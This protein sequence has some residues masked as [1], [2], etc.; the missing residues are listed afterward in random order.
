MTL[1]I[2]T[3]IHFL[4]EF[5]YLNYSMLPSRIF[6]VALVPCRVQKNVLSAAPWRTR[7]FPVMFSE[8]R[9]VFEVSCNISIAAKRAHVIKTKTSGHERFGRAN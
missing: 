5:V 4:F 1:L 2:E 8:K 3:K 9:T 6:S 7:T